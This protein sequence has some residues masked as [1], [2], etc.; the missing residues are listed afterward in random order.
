MR[1]T[2]DT[3]HNEQKPKAKQDHIHHDREMEMRNTHDVAEMSK[4]TDNDDTKS[5]TILRRP[6]FV[7]LTVNEV[8]HGWIVIFSK[9]PRSIRRG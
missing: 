2:W 4:S 9:E 8:N 5:H 3:G 7:P 6:D 1:S